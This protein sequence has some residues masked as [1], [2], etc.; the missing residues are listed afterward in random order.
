MT[1]PI[2]S[3]TMIMSRRCVLTSAGFSLGLASCLALRSFL[4]RPIGLRFRPRLKR[5]RA[6]ACTTSRSCSEERSRSLFYR[7]R[8]ESLSRGQL[9][10]GEW[11]DCNVLLEL[12]AAIGELPELSLLLELCC[13]SSCQRRRDLF[14]A[15][16]CA[17]ICA[18]VPPLDSHL[19]L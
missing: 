16:M 10:D 6:R 19:I 14:C 12:N 18:P 5:R 2:I 11:V 3:G 7:V 9:L 4:I 1:E 17:V 13:G 15:C 8:S